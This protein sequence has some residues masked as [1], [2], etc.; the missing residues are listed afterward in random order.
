M[1]TVG[2]R[3]LAGMTG[4]TPAEML[5]GEAG[6]TGIAT[7][8]PVLA[9]FR[10]DHLADRLHPWVGHRQR[11]IHALISTGAGEVEED[12]AGEMGDRLRAP[13]PLM[14]LLGGQGMHPACR[15]PGIGKTQAGEAVAVV[16][17]TGMQRQQIAQ[18]SSQV[19]AGNGQGMACGI[20]VEV[21]DLHRLAA[22]DDDV[23]A[24]VADDGQGA[25]LFGH[26]LVVDPVRDRSAQE[27]A[28]VEDVVREPG[29]APSPAVGGEVLDGDP[30]VAQGGE[31]RPQLEVDL[32]QTAH[33]IKHSYMSKLSKN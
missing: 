11:R 5:I 19:T 9:T 33:Q 29:F 2:H 1:P 28:P 3:R 20:E 10:I 26:G 4:E 31:A 27:Q 18:P 8:G 30:L 12:Q 16:D 32:A 6:P 15:P 14:L 24:V 23:V 13:G 25:G 21:E 7:D 22:G 17:Q